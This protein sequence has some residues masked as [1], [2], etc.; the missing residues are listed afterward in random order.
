MLKKRAHILLPD[1]LLADIDR[2][3]GPRGR[4]AFLI[5]VL[6]G[7]VNRRRLLELLNSPEP[8][9]RDKDHPEL[10]DGADAWVRDMRDRDTESDSTRL[11]SAA[12]GQDDSRE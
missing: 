5:E 9:W 1:D 10:A 2:L 4:T 7:E 12:N 11:R 8:I 6:R 3:V